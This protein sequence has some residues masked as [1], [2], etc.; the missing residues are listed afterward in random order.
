MKKK[1]L[2]FLISLLIAALFTITGCDQIPLGAAAEGIATKPMVWKANTKTPV[3]LAPDTDA[4]LNFGISVATDGTYA[5]VGAEGYNNYQGAAYIY[6]L[7]SGR[8]NYKQTITAGDAVNGDSFGHSVAISDP[9]IVVGAYLKSS[10]TGAVYVF[11]RNVETWSA[12]NNGDN[13]KINPIVA[14]DSGGRWGSSVAISG[15]YLLAGAPLDKGTGT[16]HVFEQDE[17]GTWNNKTMTG[18][19]PASA[20]NY[21]AAVTINSNFAAVG[22]PVDD[23][24]GNENYGAV[25]IF[26]VSGNTWNIVEKYLAND[27]ATNGRFGTSISLT[28]NICLIGTRAQN[29]SYIFQWN[30]SIWDQTDKI[31]GSTSISGDQF[32]YAVG[33]NGSFAFVGANLDDDAV[34]DSGS[35][36]V[37]SI[38][39][40]GLGTETDIFHAPTPVNGRV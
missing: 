12:I 8:W 25:Y 2:Y 31:T 10:Q 22:A 6:K 36:F 17:F 30:G 19:T 1:A 26:M 9:Y 29:A 39:S 20:A 40:S 23:D 34:S 18:A 11:E 3:L 13:G 32:G 16:A 4:N 14:I 21:G 24:T 33:F 28:G 7:E 35:S 15:K 27:P 37:F 5:V 38:N